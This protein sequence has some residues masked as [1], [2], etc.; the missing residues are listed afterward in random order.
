MGFGQQ[1]QPAEAAGLDHRE[2]EIIRV[3]IGDPLTLLLD[4]KPQPQIVELGHPDPDD[5][6]QASRTDKGRSRG[7]IRQ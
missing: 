5:S 3:G 4:Q 6:A 7:G 2:I 1:G